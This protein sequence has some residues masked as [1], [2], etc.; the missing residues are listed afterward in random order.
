MQYA[1]TAAPADPTRTQ[2]RNSATSHLQGP[3][4][5]RVG[6]C[7]TRIL[8]ETLESHI[9]DVR[10]SGDD[11]SAVVHEMLSPQAGTAGSSG[12][13]RRARPDHGQS[14]FR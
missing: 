2:I 4:R 6:L 5:L 7:E 12:G 8:S 3:Y 11:E 9:D 14:R 13:L 1:L 10:H